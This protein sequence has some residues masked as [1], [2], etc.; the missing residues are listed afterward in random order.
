MLPRGAVTSQQGVL[1]TGR[2]HRCREAGATGNVGQ[3][4]ANLGAGGICKASAQRNGQCCPETQPWAWPVGLASFI[5][6]SSHD[7]AVRL[8]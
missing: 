5:A 8:F 1:L 4:S 3:A 6:L 2:S 7:M